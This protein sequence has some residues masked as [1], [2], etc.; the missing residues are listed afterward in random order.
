PEAQSAVAQM[1]LPLLLEHPVLPQNRPDHGD[2]RSTEIVAP[3]PN[4]K[5]VVDSCG[6]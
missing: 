6:F 1:N 2:G 3:G 5:P 4:S